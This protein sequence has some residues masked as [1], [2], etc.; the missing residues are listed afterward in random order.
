MIKIQ[1]K[2]RISYRECIA[3]LKQGGVIAYPTETSY[4][5]GCDPRHT[6]ALQKIY[7]IKKREK[8]KPCILIASSMSGVKKVA[9][10]SKLSVQ[11]KKTFQK[12][13]QK[14]WPGALTMVLPGILTKTVAIRITSS[15]IAQQ[16]TKKF[17]YPI[18]STSANISGSSE[19]R[20]AISCK[21]VFKQ[22]YK[23]DFIL[24]GGT[25]KKSKPSTL[26]RILP[27]GGIEVLRQGAIEIQ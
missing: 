1:K 22:K 23:P 16:L 7:K 18:I 17:G 14:Y 19:C 8:N 21:K 4:G 3:I 10:I 25:L 9:D 27:N 26:I 5:L 24:D 13:A 6:K 20:S 12:L 2:L 15:F 11:A